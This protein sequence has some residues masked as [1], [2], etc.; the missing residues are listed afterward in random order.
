MNHITRFGNCST[1]LPQTILLI[2]LDNITILNTKIIINISDLLKTSVSTIKPTSLDLPFYSQEPKICPASTLQD[3][4][5]NTVAIRYYE[6]YLLITFKK[7]YHRASK[8]TISRWIKCTLTEW[9]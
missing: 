3:Y 6:P 8:L 1:D 4:I 7:P 5:Q 2:R 9:C